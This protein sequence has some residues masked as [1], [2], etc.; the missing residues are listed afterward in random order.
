MQIPNSKSNS[1]YIQLCKAVDIPSHPAR[2]PQ[3]ISL[4]FMNFLTEP[5][6]IVLDIFAGYNT[7]DATAEFV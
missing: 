7:T 6:D 2:F 1:R 4:F 5:G 3:Q